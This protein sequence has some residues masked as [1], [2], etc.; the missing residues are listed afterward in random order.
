MVNYQYYCK[1]CKKLSVI[2]FKKQKQP[3]YTIECKKCGG[4]MFRTDGIKSY[5]I[6]TKEN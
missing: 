2:H 1:E 3:R 6:K 4:T 5:D